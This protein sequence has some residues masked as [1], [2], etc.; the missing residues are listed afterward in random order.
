MGDSE[1]RVNPFEGKPDYSKPVGP[2]MKEEHFI[3]GSTALHKAAALLKFDEVDKLLAGEGA[4]DINTGDALDQTPLVLLARNHYDTDDVPKAVQMIEKLLAAGAHIC[5]PETGKCK[6]DQYG[7]SMLHLS[8]MAV[9]R[10]GPAVLKAL[11]D[12]LPTS[13]VYTKTQLVSARCKNFGNTALHWATLNT[14]IEACE[15]LIEAGARLDRKNRLKET[16]LDYAVKYESPR[17]K[18]KYEGLLGGN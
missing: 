11:V 5:D 4:K 1:T 6:R 16:V 12:N 17:L 10:N 13:G 2:P 3:R 8:A 15:L 9:G 14:N 18:V 7:D